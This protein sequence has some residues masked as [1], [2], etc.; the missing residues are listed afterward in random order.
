M[1]QIPGRLS[2][3]RREEI[4][5]NTVLMPAL[6]S[7]PAESDERLAAWASAPAPV[8]RDLAS[9]FI[10]IVDTAITR[11]AGIPCSLDEYRDGLELMS[12]RLGRTI[13]SL[14]VLT[15]RVEGSLPA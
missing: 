6:L 12:Q 2:D 11:A 3:R 14:P 4:P 13:A 8:A 10:D 5:M 9:I 1:R 15:V 7:Q